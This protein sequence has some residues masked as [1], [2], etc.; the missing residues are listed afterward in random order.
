[1]SDV[2]DEADGTVRLPEPPATLRWAPEEWDRFLAFDQTHRARFTR[3]AWM[4]LE[5]QVDA[6][7]AV[8]RTW[9]EL[10]EEWPSL[11]LGLNLNHHAWGVLKRHVAIQTRLRHDRYP[12]DPQLPHAVATDSSDLLDR[13]RLAIAC[14][15]ERQRITLRMRYL[16]DYSNDEIADMMSIPAAT[17]RSNLRHAHKRLARILNLPTEYNRKGKARP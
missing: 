15:P 13:V 1:M 6:E 9:D 3:Y 14:L 11:A 16:L 17:V 5:S 4:D 7:E 2:T 12:L 10:I 8:E